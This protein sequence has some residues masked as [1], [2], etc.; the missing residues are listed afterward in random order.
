MVPKKYDTSLRIR[1]SI[2]TIPIAG[3]VALIAL[4]V[5]GPLV[6]PEMNPDWAEMIASTS[7]VIA[8]Y[9][10]IVAFILPIAGF[11]ALYD[12]MAS[13]QQTAGTA[14]WGMLMS[15]WGTA[16]ALPT[17]GIMAYA[18]PVAAGL[19]A[20]GEVA[21]GQV[22]NEAFM[23][24]MILGG[25]SGILYT[26]GPL[27]LGIALWRSRSVSRWATIAFAVHGLLL[28]FGFSVFPVLIIGWVL[29]TLAGIVIATSIWNHSLTTHQPGT[30]R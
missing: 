20:Q 8:H 5:R 17:F 12:H 6:L 15:I 13:N 29:F 27:L 4:L 9:G 28:S 2:L 23:A 16:L 30:V 19:S 3:T 7:Y 10:L 21:A 25:I 11:W 24:S 22:I 14:F 1:T 26:L 18:A